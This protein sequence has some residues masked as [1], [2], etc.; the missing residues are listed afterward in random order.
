MTPDRWKTLKIS[1]LGLAC[2]LLTGSLGGMPGAV[3]AD[4]A[5]LD[6]L[7][8]SGAEKAGNKEG[9]IPA[10]QGAEAPLPGWE[11]GKLRQEY[12][13][14]KDEKPL[15]TIDASNVDKYASKLSLGQQAMIKQTKDYRMDVYPSHRT[16]GVPDFVASNTRKNLGAAVLNADGWSLKEATVP[17]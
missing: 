2:L 10:W 7:T 12:W 11:W 5:Q 6:T 4:L 15:F 14:H 1:H 13:K 8:P 3:A 9:T 16:C 17:G